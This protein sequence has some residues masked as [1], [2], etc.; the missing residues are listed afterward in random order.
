MKHPPHI[1][2]IPSVF[3][4]NKSHRSEIKSQI[5]KVI[6]LTGLS[7]AGKSTIANSLEKRLIT[8]GKHPYVLDADNLRLG[9]CRDLGFT[10]NDR[11][12][13]IRRVAETAKLMVDAGLIVI[14]SFIAPFLNDRRKARELFEGEEFIEVYV[15]APLSLCER[16]D[17]KGLYKKARAG[18]IEN[19]TGINSPYQEPVNP[20]LIIDTEIHSPES[21]ADFIITFAK[22]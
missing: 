19:F 17:P 16:R 6:W 13:N 20:E 10:I 3:E 18:E 11:S 8:R 15:N 14:T 4:M 22:Y 7:G 21:A 2:I 12:E 1:N 5:P 9:L